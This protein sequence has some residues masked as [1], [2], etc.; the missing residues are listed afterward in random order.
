VKKPASI[1]LCAAALSSLA[2]AFVLAALAAALTGAGPSPHILE[3]A[4]VAVFAAMAISWSHAL[5]HLRPRGDGDGDDWRRGFDDDDPLAPDSG[6]SGFT[7][8]WAAFERDFAAY[9]QGRFAP[10]LALA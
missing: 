7:I 3:P 1:V 8:D 2:L 6:P 9:V 4:A 5:A 10:A